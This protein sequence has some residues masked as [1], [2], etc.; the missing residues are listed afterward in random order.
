MS[1]AQSAIKE[2][3]L[4]SRLERSGALSLAA[5]IEGFGDRPAVHV[6]KCAKCARL[7][8]F[9]LESGIHRA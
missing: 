4:P 7:V 9:F 6:L 5:A 8:V 3:A 1:L 2:P